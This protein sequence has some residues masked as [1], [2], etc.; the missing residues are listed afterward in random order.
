MEGPSLYL[1]VE[2]LQPFK[3]KV[4][5]GVSGNTKAGKERLQNKKVKDIFSWAKQL[6]FQFDEF[7]LRVH[8]LLYGSFEATVN[9]KPVTGDYKKSG[10]P[11]LVLEFPNGEMKMFNS[12]VKFIEDPNLKR[13]YDFSADIMSAT[14]DEKAALKKISNYPK[15]QIA[16]VL[17]DQ[18]IFGGV[19]NIIKNEVLFLQKT[20]PKE[21][22]ENL[23]KKKLKE[24]TGEARN[25]SHKFYEWRKVFKLKA[26]LKIY[27]K[28][29]CPITG[30]KVKREK[31]GKRQRISFFCPTCQALPHPESLQ[32]ESK[33]RARHPSHD[34]RRKLR[35][36]DLFS[37]APLA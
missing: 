35:N 29:I 15:E 37:S 33:P 3:N 26:N 7:A 28:S 16:D 8:F 19:G 21:L 30:D 9:G 31:T 23:T 1:A 27:R 11:R 5:L 2:Q 4:V 36:P 6:I 24:I 18:E 32:P 13:V 14:W 22:V 10:P 25:F 34:S 20:N 17:M 12:S